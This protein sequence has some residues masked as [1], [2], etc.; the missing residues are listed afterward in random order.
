MTPVPAERIGALLDRPVAATVVV[1]VCFTALQWW[2]NARYR[3]LGAFNVDEEGGLAAAMRFHRQFGLDP[4]P[5]LGEVFSTWNGPLVPLLAIPV[6]IVG[7]DSI[8]TVMAVQSLLVVVAAVGVAGAVANIAGP[9]AATLAGVTMMLLPISVVSSRSFQYSIGVAAFLALALWALLASDRGRRRWPM[10]A[11]GLATGAMLLTRTMSASFLPAIVA[12]SVIVVARER[13][14][15]A[16]LAIAAGAA[17][18]IAGPW[19]IAE[20]DN[21][22]TYLTE[23]AYGPRARYW[24]SVAW[25][26]R[27]G[28]HFDYFLKDFR[29]LVPIGL[30]AAATALLVALVA[31]AR[32]AAPWRD[33]S[34]RPLAAVWVVLLLTRAALLSTSNLG[35]WFAHPLDMTIVIAT[36]GTIAAAPVPPGSR[37]RWR[38]AFAAIATAFLVVSFAVSLRVAENGGLADGD[39]RW[40][41]VADHAALLGGGLEADPRLHSPDGE[42]RRQVADEWF[43]ASARL[44]RE[45]DRIGAERGTLLQTVIGEIHLMNA[46]TIL[47]TEEA[48]GRGIYGLVVVNT[49]EPP[50][51][52]LRQD[53]SPRVGDAERV[54]IVVRGR[55]LAFPNGRGRERFIRLAEADGW[56]PDA[57]IELPDGGEVVV[58]VRP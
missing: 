51:A 19:W 45:I 4:R 49:L 22:T 26:D 35:Y 46:N 11:F 10:V 29:L 38:T 36:I 2:W 15:V 14:A 34:V 1:G 52:R 32:G 7:P 28:D 12:G 53:L 20:F 27:L 44:A 25:G 13:R 39:W 47:L 41:Y 5:L 23:N 48:L 30:A 16:N 55:S 50:D 17:A 3:H 6:M 57:Q 42:V 40:G 21:I 33:G 56:R 9:R 58:Y 24:G 54:L 37:A 31:R 8:S 18:M 43:R